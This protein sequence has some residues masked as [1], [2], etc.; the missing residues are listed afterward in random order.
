MCG[1]P[2]C[3]ITRVINCANFA[4]ASTVSGLRNMPHIKPHADN[5]S[6][7]HCVPTCACRMQRNHM[8]AIEAQHTVHKLPATLVK[9]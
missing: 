9:A 7:P 2:T 5:L 4:K 6:Q 8:Q 3:A 1:Q